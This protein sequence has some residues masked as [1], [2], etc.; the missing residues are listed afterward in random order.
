MIKA[1]TCTVYE[2][3]LEDK[4]GRSFSVFKSLAYRRHRFKSIVGARVER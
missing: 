3:P 4:P 2:F 1:T